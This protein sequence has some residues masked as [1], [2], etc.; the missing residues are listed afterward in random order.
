MKF[1]LKAIALA[2]LAA[3]TVSAAPVEVQRRDAASDRIAA[4]FVQLLFT[5]AWP[6]SCAAAVSI[7]LGLIRSISINQMSMDF[8]GSNPYAPTTS[9]TNIVAKMLSI[10]GI[11]LPI[12]SV[13]QHVILIDNGVQLGQFTTPWSA[14]NVKNGELQ[15]SFA[16]STL[17]VFP[18]AKVAFANFV[19]GLSTSASRSVTLKG[20]VDAKI[21][22]GLLGTVTIPG[23][24]FKATTQLAGLNNLQDIAYNVLVDPD[25]ART[26]GFLYMTSIININ[27]PS[28][29]SVSLGNITLDT[30]GPTGRAGV[31]EITNLAL[32]PGPNTIISTTALDLSLQPANDILLNLG[33]SDQVLT[34]SGFDGT[35]KNPVLNAALRTMKSTVT[36]PST[37]GKLSQPPYKDFKLKV[38]P[39]TGTDLKVEITATFASPYYGFPVEMVHSNL[40]QDN[41]AS[42]KGVAGADDSGLFFFDEGLTYKVSGTA[43]KTVSFKALLKRGAFTAGDRPRWVKMVEFGKANG[44]IPVALSFFVDIYLNNDGVDHWVDWGA[45]GAGV[46]KLD[47]AVGADFEQILGFIPTA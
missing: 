47:V 34:M 19:G 5:G 20:A 37:L 2:A 17:N 10:P 29:L 32:V 26:P 45:N 31:S 46:P 1:S 24:G 8:T 22:L 33:A 4:C 44:Y 6:G 27:N 42:V 35:S 11:D 7:D 9:S 36:V 14:A 3:A 18:D 16:S 15:T 13:R 12:T 23:I 25:M 40:G 30:A 41:Y 39:S 28:K 43:G 38:L 21:N